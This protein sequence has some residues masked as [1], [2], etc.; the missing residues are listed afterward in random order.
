MAPRKSYMGKAR[1]NVRKGRKWH[2]K[3][4]YKDTYNFKLTGN[5]NSISTL[6]GSSGPGV[7]AFGPGLQITPNPLPLNGVRCRFG[8]IMTFALSNTTQF[9]QLN[10]LFDRYKINGVRV[11]FI[12]EWN[13]ADIIGV[14]LLPVMK[15]A[16]D[17]DDVTVPTLGDIWSRRGKEY[18]LDKPFSVYVKPKTLHGIWG[19]SATNAI[20]PAGTNKSVYLNTG[21]GAVPHLGLKF[22][23]KD[24][25]APNSPTANVV[26]RIE[27][28]YFVSFKEQINVGAY[29]HDGQEENTFEPALEELV[30]EVACELKPPV[31]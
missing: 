22:G 25:Y 27:T 8:G 17:L 12:P 11:R 13:S 24:W 18:R 21:Y 6:V 5:E 19:G 31:P 26:L 16:M 4:K 1:K 15:V 23:I 28:T 30:E 3:R 7:N 14:G 2:G 10:T 29:G 20:F 9:T